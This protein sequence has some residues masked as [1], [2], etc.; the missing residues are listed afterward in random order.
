MEVKGHM[1]KKIK[2]M[3]FSSASLIN[4]N[5]FGKIMY[6]SEEEKTANPIGRSI[7]L[8]FIKRRSTKVIKQEKD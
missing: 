6:G 5:K 3:D 2:D 8:N 4:P 7:S 1:I